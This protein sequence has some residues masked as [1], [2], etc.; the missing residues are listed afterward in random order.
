[1]MFH[2]GSPVFRGFQVAMG[3]LHRQ[4]SYARTSFRA[5]LLDISIG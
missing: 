2:D 3:L 5:E 1:M 4:D